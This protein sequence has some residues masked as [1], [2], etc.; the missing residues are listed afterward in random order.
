MTGTNALY[1]ARGRWDVVQCA[2][3]SAPQ[4]P[5]D[6]LSHSMTPRP[7]AEEEPRVTI[8]GPKCSKPYSAS[9]FNISAMSF[10]SLGPNAVLALNT[11]AKMGNFYH[12]TG[13]G[14]ISKYHRQPGGDLNWQIGS[15]GG[16]ILQSG[17]WSLWPDCE[18]SLGASQSDSNCASVIH[19]NSWLCVRPCWRQK[20]HPT[21]SPPPV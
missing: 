16:G 13:E 5:A 10:G 17:C 12:T 4:A 2:R 21:S 18:S 1:R 15:G 7:A 6:W 3:C 8:G 14:G 11:G 20:P 19:G 9:V